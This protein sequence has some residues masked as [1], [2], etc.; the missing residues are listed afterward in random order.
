MIVMRMGVFRCLEV[1]CCSHKTVAICCCCMPRM[2]T[3]AT[4]TLLV[5]LLAGGRVRIGRRRGS[6]GA[7]VCERSCGSCISGACIQHL[8]FCR[9]PM[10][11][12]CK[13]GQISVGDGADTGAYAC[14][15]AQALASGCGSS[16]AP[17]SQKNAGH[18]SPVSVWFLT[19]EIEAARKI[20]C[21]KDRFFNLYF[22][23]AFDFARKFYRVATIHTIS[24]GG[25]CYTLLE[26]GY[27]YGG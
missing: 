19:P 6:L 1:L 21:L 23:S 4:S 11:M 13:R 12:V 26:W 8:C 17:S 14:Q 27:P 16:S 10:R 5:L 22:F 18:P 9:V 7:P 3:S 25:C 2:W 15:L 20:Q 24:Q